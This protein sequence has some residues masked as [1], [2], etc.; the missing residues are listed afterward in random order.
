[1]GIDVHALQFLRWA[2]FKSNGLGSVATIGRQNLHILPQDLSKIIKLPPDYEHLAFGE[3]LLRRFLGATQVRS[4]DK[5]GYEG[6]DYVVD[7][8]DPVISR[9]LYQTVFDGG[10]LEHI[11][12]VPQ[13][14]KNISSLCASGGQILHVL[15]ANNYCGHGFWQFSPELFFSLYSEKNGYSAT[16]VFIADLA[17]QR[18]WYEVIKPA[19][20]K[21]AV[22]DSPNPLYVLCRTVK[23]GEA[24]HSDVQQSDYIFAWEGHQAQAAPQTGLFNKL[25][26]IAK[27]CK[28]GYLLGP[29]YL[30]AKAFFSSAALAL[31]GHPLAGNPALIKRN[32]HKLIYHLQRE[33]NS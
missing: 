1:M 4:F 11:Y 2:A 29:V 25:K 15:P 10:C 16:E 17:D 14:L 22:I 21:R 3:E 30:K 32:I 9:D 18:N 7:M 33:L 6:A 26:T 19:A 24:S 31:N 28:L 5:S 27:Q 8:N 20:G 23:Q 13:A 12:N